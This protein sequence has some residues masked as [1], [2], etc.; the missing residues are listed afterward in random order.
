MTSMSA[1]YATHLIDTVTDNDIIKA[2]DHDTCRAV[3]AAVWHVIEIHSVLTE[4]ST[5]SAILGMEKSP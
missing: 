3:E 2:T 5:W 4:K 1:F